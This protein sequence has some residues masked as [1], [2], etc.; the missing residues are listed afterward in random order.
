MI[1]LL[2]GHDCLSAMQPSRVNRFGHLGW[3]GSVE[4]AL[5]GG[6]LALSGCSTSS[7]SRVLMPAPDFPAV[8]RPLDASVGSVTL[9]NERLRFVVLDYSFSTLPPTG[10]FLEVYRSSTRVGRVRLSRWSNP[11]T[12]AADFVE[13]TPRVGDIARPD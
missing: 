3:F 12:A 8:I 6:V 11:T 7:R 13:G 9:V 1:D 10:S 5:F 2:A 4:A